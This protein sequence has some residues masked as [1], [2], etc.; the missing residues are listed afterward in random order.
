MHGTELISIQTVGDSTRM[1]QSKGFSLDVKG[2]PTD[3]LGRAHEILTML[4]DPTDKWRVTQINYR[5]PHVEDFASNGILFVE[6]F[7]V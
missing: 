4:F 7:R 5:P 6:A 2:H 1:G 3:S